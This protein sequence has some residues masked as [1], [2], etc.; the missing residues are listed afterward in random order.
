MAWVMPVSFLFT[1]CVTIL[2][3]SSRSA[4]GEEGTF[5]F[6]ENE[7]GFRISSLSGYL[8][9]Y[10]VSCP[11]LNYIGYVYYGVCLFRW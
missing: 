8:W 5:S 2:V 11:S 3:G 6:A 1:L 4:E 10:T 9:R 7:L